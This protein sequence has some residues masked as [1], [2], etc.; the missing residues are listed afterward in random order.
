MHVEILKGISHQLHEVKKL[1]RA[2]ATTLGFFPEGAFEEYASKGCILVASDQTGL[3]AGYL[4]FRRSGDRLAIVHLCVRDEMR[5]RR[6]ARAIFDALL[7][8]S[9]SFRG[10]NVSCRRDFSASALW[11]QLGFVAVR[12]KRG[13]GAKNTVL[14]NWWF[15]CG[16]PDL[17]SLSE[18]TE[19][20]Q[21][22]TV[23]IDANVFYDLNSPVEPHTEESK[24]LQADW[25]Q[26]SVELHITPEILNEINRH[27]T[28]SHRLNNRRRAAQF[29]S[30]R[31]RP[32]KFAA[33]ESTVKQYFRSP[34]SKSDASD[35]RQLAWT[36]ASGCRFFVTRDEKVLNLSPRLYR[37]FGISAIRPSDL[38]VQL[39][40]LQERSK[41]NP[42]RVAGVLTLRRL[43]QAPTDGFVR[44]LQA[45]ERKETK[46]RFRER[47]CKYLAAPK[48]CHCWGLFWGKEKPAALVVYERSSKA[49]LL[50]PFMRI[51]RGADA[52]AIVRNLLL[53]VVKEAAAEKRSKIVITDPYCLDFVEEELRKDGFSR[54]DRHWVKHTM[55]I[56]VT[57]KTFVE[58][59]GSIGGLGGSGG[60]PE[61]T[62][63]LSEIVTSDARTA[64]RLE[65]AY[66]P[67]KI[68]DA[69]LPSYIIPIQPQWAAELFDDDLANQDLFGARTKLSLNREGVYYRSAV[70][71]GGLAAP[72]RIL[73]YVS[74]D[75]KYQGSK[76]IR[77]CSFLDDVVVGRPKELFR[78]FDRLG[79]YEWK[80]LIELAKGDI[81]T[82]LMAV[83]YSDTQLLANPVRWDTF[84]KVLQAAGV[85]TQLQSPQLIPTQVFANLYRQGM[86]YK[87]NL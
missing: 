75:K 5:G 14:T 69:P 62:R 9:K 81:D 63:G 56:A 39:D 4:L 80:H 72:G 65:R 83:R 40:E 11:P 59:I 87:E 34:L 41:Y 31:T 37:E 58:Q 55:P 51:A 2:N 84:Q 3:L 79:V 78:R 35:V 64:H 13:R 1:W 26:S 32:D 54:E 74:D 33:A 86:G 19:T 77:A 60:K 30:V 48:T 52:V 23:V 38:I 76:C 28:P 29:A 46:A 42:A 8:T 49:E 12:E 73:W 61:A 10:I 57:A 17:F 16:N 50:V 70:P 44:A 15:D 82:S 7:T 21:K 18:K 22:I 45:P 66:W 47:F 25:L 24:A 27:N 85:R 67:L 68:I 53:R 20:E 36:I 43:Q 6:I 71:T